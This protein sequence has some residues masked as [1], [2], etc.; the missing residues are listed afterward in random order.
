MFGLKTCLR[1]NFATGITALSGQ[2]PN[3]KL[4]RMG[5]P[6]GLA[7]GLSFVVWEPKI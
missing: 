2:E 3:F 5:L 4:G 7:G 6:N 1:A